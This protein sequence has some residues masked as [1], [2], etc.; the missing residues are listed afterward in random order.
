MLA[1]AVRH[2]VRRHGV[3]PGRRA[4]VATSNDDGY[5]SLCP[6]RC[7]V[8]VLAVLDSRT[9]LADPWWSGRGR[10]LPCC[11]C[12]ADRHPRGR[13]AAFARDRASE[14]HRTDFAADLLAMSGGF[15][16]VVHL[17]K[18]AGGDLAWDADAQAFLPGTARQA[19]ASI[20]AAAGGHALDA[21]LAQ[22]WAAGGGG[23][24]ALRWT[25][26]WAWAPQPWR[27]PFLRQCAARLSSISRTTCRSA[28]SIWPGAKAIA[29]SSISSAIP[30]WAWARTRAR[31]ATWPRWPAGAGAR[32]EIPQA[33]LTTFRPP[34]TPTTLGAFAGAAVR[35]H[36]GPV[37]RLRL[38]AA[39]EALGAVWQPVGYWF[40]PRGYPRSG[41]SL[42]AASLRERGWCGKALAWWMFPRWQ[43]SRIAGPDAAALLEMACATTIGRLAWGAAAIP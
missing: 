36:A 27:R 7:R 4:V 2:Y 17:H 13:Q 39:H 32:V 8:Q 41:E 15:T 9:V 34:Y 38:H 30:R 5:R 42:G 24:R 10:A 25:I 33:G 16:P 43:R 18:Q 35:D 40:R 23:A 14:R 3:V 21:I 26:R 1:Q 11:R 6:G 19:Q 28:M 37:R 31:P 22:G 29:R 12:A 20:G